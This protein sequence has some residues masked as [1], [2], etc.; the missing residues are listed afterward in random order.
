MA[1]SAGPSTFSLSPSWFRDGLVSHLPPPSHACPSDLLCMS[2]LI[3]LQGRQEPLHRTLF[4]LNYLFKILFLNFKIQPH[5]E[6][7]DQGFPP[8]SWG[9]RTDTVHPQRPWEAV[10]D[11]VRGAQTRSLVLPFPLGHCQPCDWH[12]HHAFLGLTE[13]GGGCDSPMVVWVTGS[14]SGTRAQARSLPGLRSKP[15]CPAAKY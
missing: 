4:Y 5:S 9:A 13:P 11:A 12:Q 7:Q 3:S 6:V 1:S 8:R 10:T 15:W 14:G 2:V